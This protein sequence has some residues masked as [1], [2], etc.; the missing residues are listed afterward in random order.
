MFEPAARRVLI[1]P[2]GFEWGDFHLTEPPRAGGKEATAGPLQQQH[3]GRD[4][5]GTAILPV[6]PWT[7]D[8]TGDRGSR[9]RA[10]LQV[11]ALCRAWDS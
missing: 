6:E 11:P 1:G 7:G 3:G 9:P 4:R 5:P 10:G 2:R 8:P